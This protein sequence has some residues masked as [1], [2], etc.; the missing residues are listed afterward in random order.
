MI[1]AESLK[2]RHG[3][4]LSF[5]FSE[6]KQCNNNLNLRTVLWNIDLQPLTK[7]AEQFTMFG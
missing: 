6:M 2:S 4:S 7:A 3:K 1:S 5:S